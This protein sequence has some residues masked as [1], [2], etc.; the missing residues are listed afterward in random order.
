MENY[1][2]P[3]WIASILGC[4]LIVFAALLSIHQFQLI[5]GDAQLLSVSATA[6]AES[7]PDL[8]VVTVGV[9]SEGQTAQAVKDQSSNKMNQVISFIKQAGIND[10]DVTTSQFYVSPKYNYSNQ[11]QT[12]VGYQANQTIT[13]KVRNVDKSTQ[14]LEKIVDGAV[15]NGANQ[16]QGIDFSFENNE[17]LVQNAQKQ[18]IIKARANAQQIANDAGLKLGRAVNVITS[19]SGD[20]PVPMYAAKMALADSSASQ[21]EAGSQD[22]FATVTVVFEIR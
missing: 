14:Q 1:R 17:D 9:V 12:V 11:Q 13:V 6:K 21:I 3:I 10:K 19:N 2:L 16:I 4:M 20:R 7:V 8:A 5:R 22:V 18:A 15:M